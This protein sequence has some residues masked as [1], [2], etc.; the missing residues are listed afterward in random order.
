MLLPLP[1]QNIISCGPE[2]RLMVFFPGQRFLA[3]KKRN[4]RLQNKSSESLL[5]AQT[6]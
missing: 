6:Y 5:R 3:I 2:R 4:H 1:A